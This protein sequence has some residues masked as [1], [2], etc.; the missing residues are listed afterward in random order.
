VYDSQGRDIW[1]RRALLRESDQI[2]S[3]LP[4]RAVVSEIP[5]V[6][7]SEK[8]VAVLK[9]VLDLSADEPFP[10][11]S[12]AVASRLIDRVTIERT[13]AAALLEDLIL[14]KKELLTGVTEQSAA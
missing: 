13:A 2:L 12:S 4:K 6:P 14:W 1:E 10:K 8:Q 9:K 7:A 11:I 3:S 5:I